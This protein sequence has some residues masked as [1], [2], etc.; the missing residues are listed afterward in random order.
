[1]SLGDQLEELMKQ[2]SRKRE[3]AEENRRRIGEIEATATAVRQTVKVTV[4]ALG[5]LKSI[6]FPTG[7]Y[8]RMA[9]KE[10]ADALLSTIEE[11][12]AEVS[13]KVDEAVPSPLP[14]VSSSALLQGDFDMNDLLPETPPIADSVRDF[15]GWEQR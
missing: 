3:E 9:P 5:Q 14:G 4:G 10:L 7:A 12:K 8:R 6:E 15:I 1:M 2:Y 11:A 13:K